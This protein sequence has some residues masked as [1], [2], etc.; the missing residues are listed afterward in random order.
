MKDE[1]KEHMRNMG[2]GWEDQRRHERGAERRGKSIEYQLYARSCG[3][4]LMELI[5]LY[6]LTTHEVG[7]TMGKAG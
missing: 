3:R 5:F 7:I 4:W 2:E 1:R 6:P